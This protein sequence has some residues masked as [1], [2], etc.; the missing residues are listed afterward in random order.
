[1]ASALKDLGVEHVRDDLWNNLPR[2]Y[3]EMN[4]I[5][6]N[7]KVKYDLILGN[8]SRGQAPVEY[9]NTVA[10]HL[11]GAV[12][13]IEGPNEWDNFG[14]SNWVTQLRDYQAKLHTAAKANSATARLPLLA[15]ALAFRE[16]YSQ[17]GTQTGVSDVGNSHLYPGG[18]KPSVDIAEAQSMSE[19][20]TGTSSTIVTEA[21][22]QN[23]INTTSGHHPVSEGVAATYLPRMLAEH[24]LAGT[25]RVYTY[26]LI[27]GAIDESKAD[28]EAHFGLLRHD[29]S[30]KPAYTAMK[31][32]LALLDDTDAAF[33]PG[34]LAYRTS[35][36]GSDLRQILTQRSDGTFVLLLW[37]DVTI[38]NTVARTRIAVDDTDVTVSLKDARSYQVHKPNS[39]AAPVVAGAGYDVTIPIGSQIV[40]VSLGDTVEPSEV[41]PPVVTE[42]GSTEPVAVPATDPVIAAAAEVTADPRPR[43]AK[44]KW[45]KLGAG[46][47]E[48]LMSKTTWQVRVFRGHERVR[49]INRSA[50]TLSIR[51]RKLSPD[52][53]YRFAVVGQSRAGHSSKPAVSRSVQP[54]LL[55]D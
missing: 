34:A 20:R 39:S 42:T 49:T 18:R 8:P 15:P 53:R 51:V 37:R 40:A 11:T 6:Q 4:Y 21:G 27:D 47:N 9:V 23:A 46:P 43:G 19:S 32:M 2:S 38:W 25:E 12:E 33:T 45:K 3:D 10:K 14:P 50:N 54:R 44:V 1:M 24:V 30:P 48:T 36:G 41:T 26:E 13:A 52:H 28:I 16:N 17:L 55:H 7:A 35:G 29:W 31:N 22:Y 5:A